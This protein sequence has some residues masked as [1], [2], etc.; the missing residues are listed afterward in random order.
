[1][2]TGKDTRRAVQDLEWWEFAFGSGFGIGSNDSDLN[3]VICLEK[4]A[5]T[6]ARAGPAPDARAW[7]LAFSGQ[8]HLLSRT[9]S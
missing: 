3:S 2:E 7:P 4:L 9:D 5:E 6:T 8:C 1:M